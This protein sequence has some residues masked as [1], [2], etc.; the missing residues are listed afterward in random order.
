MGARSQERHAPDHHTLNMVPDRDLATIHSA[1]RQQDARGGGHQDDLALRQRTTTPATSEHHEPGTIRL[2]KM[3]AATA[4]QE[5][6]WLAPFAHRVLVR[7]LP[8]ALRHPP[9]RVAENRQVHGRRSAWRHIGG[10]S[11]LDN[12]RTTNN[13]ETDNCGKAEAEATM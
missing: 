2:G 10:R 11:L 9:Q 7:S 13:P 12:D 5:R 1:R 4:P 6:R 8:Q 3:S